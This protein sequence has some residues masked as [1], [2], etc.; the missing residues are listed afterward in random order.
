MCTKK[1]A[2][3]N[4]GLGKREQSSSKI[5]E[6]EAAETR[7]NESMSKRLFCLEK[8]FI[9]QENNT[10]GYP[11]FVHYVIT[12]YNWKQLCAHPDDVCVPVVN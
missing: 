8:G 7:F 1:V 5:F 6:C 9:L 12:M 10:M 2:C 3:K 4:V 11:P